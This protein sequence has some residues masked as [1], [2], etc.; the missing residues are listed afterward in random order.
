MSQDEHKRPAGSE[1]NNDQGVALED[2][3]EGPT[4]GIG[5][6]FREEREKRGLSYSQVFKITRVRPY[7]L[8][9]LENEDWDSLP[10]P[11]FVRGF[12]RS[13]A[14]ALGLDKDEVVRVY[15]G[16]A[17]TEDTTL[18][19]PVVPSRRW[20]K[21][22]LPIFL[23]LMLMAGVSA[24]FIWR[25]YTTREKV[26]VSAE[27]NALTGRRAGE[28]QDEQLISNRSWRVVLA[29]EK[30]TA[31]APEKAPAEK[32]EDVPPDDSGKV[33]SPDGTSTN[34]AGSEE[35]TGL[36]L[37]AAVKER[38]WVRIFVDDQDPKE[39]IFQPGSKPEWTAN[40]GFE[41][42]IGNAGGIEL[43]LNG[44]RVEDLG[45][46]GQVVR[47]RLPKDNEQSRDFE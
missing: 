26:T 46:S 13:Y 41:L 11:G 17:L 39:Y 27:T 34:I 38:T 16:A 42:V 6:L 1:P 45:R 37:R 24:Y 47:L 35:E 43:E 12:V 5:S 31:T 23:V 10:S 20:K 19:P 18:T 9:A 2:G 29:Q 21:L 14:I 30:E 22:L 28:G 40:E 32:G 25:E 36:V 8:E 33:S 4:G 3:G 7:I 15:R 44:Q